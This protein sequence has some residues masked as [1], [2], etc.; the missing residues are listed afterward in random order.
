VVHLRFQTQ[1]R[2]IDGL[3]IRFAESEQRDD[4]A[5]WGSTWA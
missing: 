3:E 4:H 1:F 2:T 5:S